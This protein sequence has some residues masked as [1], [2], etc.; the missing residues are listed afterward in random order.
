MTEAVDNGLDLHSPEAP[1]MPP[2]PVEP[3]V[4]T[5]LSKY[6][7]PIIEQKQEANFPISLRLSYVPIKSLAFYRAF[8]DLRQIR[9]TLQ[10]N[11]CSGEYFLLE[12]AGFP[13]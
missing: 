13:F 11:Q 4:K 8:F 2:R 3:N 6:D 10:S 5:V 9:H 12:V 1:M 7:C